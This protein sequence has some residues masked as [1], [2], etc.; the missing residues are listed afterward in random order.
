MNLDD[1]NENTSF[2]KSLYWIPSTLFQALSFNDT[3]DSDMRSR[4][5]QIVDDVLLPKSLS[6]TAR[7][8]GIAM[9]IS[10]ISTDSNAFKWLSKFL[11]ERAESQ[12]GLVIGALCARA[13][14]TLA[15]FASPSEDSRIDNPNR[16]PF[17]LRLPSNPTLKQEN[18]LAP[19]RLG[20]QIS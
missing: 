19:S 9:I 12:V 11:S 15:L 1:Q 6:A 5:I 7:T 14:V 3:V 20:P 4:I 8:A 10:C 16:A 13:G 2:H 18:T 17:P